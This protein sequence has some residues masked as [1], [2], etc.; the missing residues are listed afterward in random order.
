MHVSG[1]Q[2]HKLAMGKVQKEPW[3]VTHH[4]AQNHTGSGKKRTPYM[5]KPA[6]QIK[7]LFEQKV[8]SCILLPFQEKKLKIK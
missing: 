7:L 5:T 8:F 2:P 4:I 1:K 3:V 6:F